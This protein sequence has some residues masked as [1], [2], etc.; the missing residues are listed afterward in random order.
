MRTIAEDL[1]LVGTDPEGRNLLSSYRDVAIGGALLSELAVQERLTIDERKRL[2][3]VVGGSTGDEL[4]DQALVLFTK[5]EGKKP[6][7]V[8]AKVGKELTGPVLESLSRQELVHQEPVKFIGL[9]LGSRWPVVTGG[10][11]QEVLDALVRTIT[12][13]EEPGHRT[14]ALVSLLYA[15]DVLPK[16]VGKD[17]RPGMTN[18]D[19]KRRG[20]EILQGRWASEAV[21]RAVQEAAAAMTATIAAAGAASSS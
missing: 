9:R 7:D 13:A 20:K 12:G 10:P 6:K 14:G 17:L 4:L 8:L 1:V 16:V 5:R 21:A 18:R 19:V 3:V 11:R 15:V 2:Q